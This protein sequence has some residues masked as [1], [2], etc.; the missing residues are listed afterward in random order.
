MSCTRC[1]ACRHCESPFLVGRR[2]ADGKDPDKP[3]KVMLVIDFPSELDD[4]VKQVFYGK[5]VDSYRLALHQNDIDAS[6]IYVTALLK[7]RPENPDKIS[8]EQKSACKAIFEVEVSRLID[9]DI[10]VPMSPLA[11]RWCGLTGTMGNACGNAYEKTVL[12]RD[13]TVI[14]SYNPVDIPE[15]PGYKSG[16]IQAVKTLKDVLKNGEIRKFS[17]YKPLNTIEEIEAEITRMMISPLISFDIESSGLNP[18]A[19]DA[20]LAS[21]NLTDRTHYGVSIPLHT[22]GTPLT[23]EEIE[24]AIQLIKK[25]LENPNSFKLAQN[26]KF[27]KKYLRVVAGIKVANFGF[28][29]MLGHYLCIDETP[30]T[31]GL[32][33]QAWKYFPDLG[34]YDDALEKYKKEH[35]KIDERGD[36][37]KIPWS[38]LSIYGGG[39]VDTVMRLFDIYYPIIKKNPKWDILFHKVLMPGSDTLE[40]IEV[41]GAKIDMERAKKFAAA[42]SAE[43]RRLAEQLARTPEILEL[44]REWERLAQERESLKAIKKSDRTPEQQRKFTEYSKYRG[45]KFNWGSTSDLRALLFGKLGLKSDELTESGELSTGS[46]AMKELAKQHPLPASILEWRKISKLLNDFVLKM[47]EMTDEN[48]FSHTT[49]NLTGTATGRLSSNNFNIQQIPRHEEN[50]LKFQYSY[51]PKSLFVS[52]FGEDGLILNADYCALEVRVA[53]I[54]SG[55]P[56]YKSALLSGTDFHKVTAST[57]FHKPVDEVTK[58][59]RQA[60]KAVTFGLLYGKSGAALGLDIFY[61]KSGKDPAKTSDLKAAKQKGEEFRQQYLD[62]FPGIKKYI[63]DYQAFCHKHGYVETLFGRRRRMPDINSANVSLM[64]RAERQCINAPIQGSGSDF[65]M[66]SLI[67]IN[68]RL[69]ENHMKS[70]IMITVHDSIVVDVYLPEFPVVCEMMKEVMENVWKPYIPTTEIPVEI[71]LEAGD[72]YGSMTGIS[73]EEA[74]E[75][76]DRDSFRA[77]FDSKMAKKAVSAEI[78]A[79]KGAGYSLEQAA[80]WLENNNRPMELISDDLKKLYESP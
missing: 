68:R 38:I 4:S 80:K 73:L 74:A 28:D 56:H 22:E 41:N 30:G 67:E 72:S 9:P 52:R 60:A 61:D 17:G 71:D 63:Q 20:R 55:D 12:G 75:I 27:D 77:W 18:W 10:I 62:S 78:P 66:L 59:E 34:G 32:K 25:L 14:P 69:K 33:A 44:E 58:A 31:Q 42:Y 13:R 26:G 11:F 6:D 37:S 45:K 47:P 64:R 54:I 40:D 1:D 2:L 8:T 51:E 5:A 36:Y 65:T 46:D 48:G 50:P 23:E 39:D 29:S 15:H 7:C 35:M 24:R 79:L 21:M 43:E 16:V 3:P 70:V 57:V 76:T 53:A 19:P 49:F